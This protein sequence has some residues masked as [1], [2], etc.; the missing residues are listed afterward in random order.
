M[1][2]DARGYRLANTSETQH[3]VDT[4]MAMLYPFGLP[5][6]L[7]DE[8]IAEQLDK[9]DKRRKS[10]RKA[11]STRKKAQQQEATQ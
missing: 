8:D 7:S 2:I 11:A 9:S 3:W 4:Y 1:T 5:P 6:H 10:A